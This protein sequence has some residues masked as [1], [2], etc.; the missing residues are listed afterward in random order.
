[1]TRSH[2]RADRPRVALV[3]TG[4]H[5]R[6][7][8]ERVVWEAAHH[9]SGR[10]DLVIVAED[11]DPL[12]PS[13]DVVRIPRAPVHG[14]LAQRRFRRLAGAAVSDIG[15]DVIVSFGSDCPDGD[16]LVVGSVHRAWLLRGAA[17]R[18]GTV[19]VPAFVRS[20][21]L[22]HR[23]HLAHERATLRRLRR[24]RA[25]AVAVSSSVADDLTRLYGV[26]PALIEVVPN[27][28]DPSECEVERIERLRVEVRD[29]LQIRPG[30]NVLVLVANEYHRKGLVVL[31]EAMAD[32]NR[33][34]IELLLV[35]R[36]APDAFRPQMRALG[37]DNRV[38]WVGSTNDVSRYYAAADLFV[39]PTQYEAFGSVIVE[40][41]ACGLPVVTSELA[42][43]A[44]VVS[45]HRN[46]LLLKDPLDASELT[47]CLRVAL[48]PGTL[49]RWREACRPSVI[50]YEWSSV[51]Q[52]LGDIV[53]KVAAQQS[54]RDP[55]AA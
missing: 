49:Q 5:R 37:L 21:L 28:F 43:A 2:E 38:R 33:E 30:S 44:V 47:E 7:G 17:V 22:R 8:V 18:I 4:C 54:D 42:G 27:G 20:L 53:E 36:M 50:G 34:D 40:A 51:M 13:V 14:R 3:Y 48:E 46:G 12:P 55:A 45:P 32:S 26:S 15:A 31:L 52:R 41:L 16:V 29:E 6:G 11:V 10:F 1:M 39:L 35:G 23:I 24:R 25:I 9:L 19:K